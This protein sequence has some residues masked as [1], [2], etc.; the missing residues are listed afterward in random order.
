M[1]STVDNEIDIGAMRKEEKN[2]TSWRE[3]PRKLFRDAPAT[4]ALL[5]EFRKKIRICT[6]RDGE[7]NQH[8]RDVSRI[9]FMR[10]AGRK[11]ILL[12][13]LGKKIRPRTIRVGKK[14]QR[15]R[16]AP[17]RKKCAQRAKEKNLCCATR[18][19]KK[20][21]DPSFAKFAERFELD[22]PLC[23]SCSFLLLGAPH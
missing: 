16:E 19:G 4:K 13:E 15:R 5:T 22:F 1:T 9:K 21:I 12:A 14:D 18:Q 8:L 23:V 2:R 17:R 11:K 7:K 10:D 6:I 3:V 20:N